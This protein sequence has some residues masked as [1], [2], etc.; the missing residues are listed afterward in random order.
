MHRTW[1][2]DFVHQEK[3][4]WPKLLQIILITWQIIC[5]CLSLEKLEDVV[6]LKW[7]QGA[8]GRSHWLQ[9][10]VALHSWAAFDLRC[11]ILMPK[12]PLSGRDYFL[13]LHIQAQVS[14]NNNNN[15]NRS[16]VVKINMPLRHDKLSSIQKGVW[17]S[18]SWPG[19]SST[20]VFHPPT[21]MRSRA[22]MF[23]RWHC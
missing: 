16:A 8:C 4:S 6:E 14:N 18:P 11:Y 21:L 5:Y 15:N 9:T 1:I 2:G 3:T 20:A 12:E 17:P 13:L 7:Q 10:A 19:H 22:T 23:A